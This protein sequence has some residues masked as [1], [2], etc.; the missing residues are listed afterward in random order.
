MS[1]K[2]II[3]IAI[4]LAVLMACFTFPRAASAGSWCGSTYVVQPGDW[5]SKIANRC[6]VTLSA[7]Y[8]A[9]P[10]ASY[11]RYIYPGQVLNIP[12]GSGGGPYYYCGPTYSAYYGN[13][14]VV[15]RGDTLSGIARYYGESV[16]YMAWHNGIANPNRIWPY[17]RVWI[18]R[19]T[20][21]LRNHPGRVTSLVV[22]PDDQS[23]HA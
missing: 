12:G 18:S 13:Y 23:L 7:L 10:W 17:F 19:K 6:G 8:A 22:Q 1:A 4:I 2:R 3:Q 21:R 15:C 5:L 11:Y 9:N 16:A 20:I 14:Y